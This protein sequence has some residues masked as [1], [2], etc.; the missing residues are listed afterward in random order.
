MSVGGTRRR[1]TMQDTDLED[2]LQGVGNVL[3]RF[4]SEHLEPHVGVLPQR[5]TLG[6]LTNTHTSHTHTG[7]WSTTHKNKNTS[8][9]LAA[10]SCRLSRGGEAHREVQ[11]CR[12]AGLA[13]RRHKSPCELLKTSITST[14]ACVCC[15]ARTMPVTRLVAFMAMPSGF[16]IDIT[17]WPGNATHERVHT[18]HAVPR[19]SAG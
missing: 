16:A 7:S 14:F 13:L 1:E 2:D 10:S 5:S 11:R 19:C 17:C 15:T 4:N 3:R 8:E 9:Q 12:V 18:R 6:P